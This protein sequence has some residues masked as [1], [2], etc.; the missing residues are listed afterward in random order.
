[1]KNTK[2]TC[3]LCDNASIWG[4]QI[5]NSNR[6]AYSQS[7]RNMYKIN[8]LLIKAYFSHCFILHFVCSETPF[9]PCNQHKQYGRH[10]SIIIHQSAA[11]VHNAL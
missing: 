7:R 5:Y 9:C 1:M 6:I 3:E 8:N 4:H 11:V 10:S 2:S